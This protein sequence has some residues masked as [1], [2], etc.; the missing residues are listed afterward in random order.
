MRR[1][2][3]PVRSANA[4]DRNVLGLPLALVVAAGAAAWALDGPYAA[5]ALVTLACYEIALSVDNAVPMAGVAGRL[6]PRMRQVFLTAGLFAG[7]VVMRLFV[8]PLAVATAGGEHVAE[9]TADMVADPAGY[10]AALDGVRP[11]L[12]G[13]GGVFLWL[14]FSEFL[15]NCERKDRPLW[16]APLERPFFRLRRPRVVQFAVAAVLAGLAA[17]V[18]APTDR[19]TVAV[20][21]LVGIGGYALVKLGARHVATHALAVVV[22]RALAV[23]LLLEVLDDTYSFT[24]TGTDLPVWVRLAIALAGVSIGAVFLVR[25]TRKLDAGEALK[26]YEHLPAG[27]AYVLG[28]LGILLWASLVTTIPA[29]LAAWFGAVVIGASLVSSLVR[30]RRRGRSLR[31]ADLP[32]QRRRSPTGQPRSR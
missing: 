2:L 9:T 14:V 25:L 21:G 20:A 18:G 26:R 23:F 27:A 6:H 3:R 11:E 16:I 19:D 30:N 12:A 24:D 8:P 10:A 28:V 5:A 4:S 13:F 1:T 7:V 15:F 29:A 22:E 32:V 31:G 17:W